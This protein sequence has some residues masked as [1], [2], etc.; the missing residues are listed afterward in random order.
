MLS[1]KSEIDPLSEC[2]RQVASRPAQIIEI[3]CSSLSHQTQRNWSQNALSI[4]TLKDRQPLIDD[5]FYADEDK[6]RER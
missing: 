6:L 3:N 4:V 2:S 1:F 5:L